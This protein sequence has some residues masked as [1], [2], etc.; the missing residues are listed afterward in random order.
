MYMPALRAPP[1]HTGASPPSILIILKRFQSFLREK[2]PQRGAA[3]F[4]VSGGYFG[5]R[6][7]ALRGL[8]MGWHGRGPSWG[9][10][11]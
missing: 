9:I 10:L 11:L 8:G 3:G 1:E 6:L 2:I 4:E 5:G 7:G